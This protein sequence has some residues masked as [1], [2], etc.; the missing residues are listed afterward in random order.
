MEWLRISTST[1]LEYL[2]EA[3]K[4]LF[5]DYNDYLNS[6]MEEYNSEKSDEY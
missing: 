4:E 1:E 6:I 2:Y 5:G 3:N